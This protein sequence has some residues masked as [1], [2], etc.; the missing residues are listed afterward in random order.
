MRK[1]K[2]ECAVEEGSDAEFWVK[3]DSVTVS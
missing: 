3:C 2:G 1:I